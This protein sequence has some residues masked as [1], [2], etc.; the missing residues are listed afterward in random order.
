MKYTPILLTC[1]GLFFGLA[2]PA[3]TK[4]KKADQSTSASKML[5]KTDQARK[6]IASKNKNEA[7]QDITDA[8]DAV[9]VI[10]IQLVPIYP[11]LNQT[12]VLG[13]VITERRRQ[14]GAADRPAVDQTGPATQ[15][16]YT[17][18][19]VDTAKAKEQLNTAKT[20]LQRGDAQGADQALAAVQNGVVLVAVESE[21]SL[22]K[23]RQDL[24]AA[25]AMAQQ[26]RLGDATASLRAAMVNLDAYAKTSGARHAGE[27]AKLQQDIN[28]NIGSLGADSSAA[29]DKI[30]TWWVEIIELSPPDQPR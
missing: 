19:A 14:S 9:N 22:L 21:A 4:S 18:V 6:A 1:A 29:A 7:L 25:K 10:E 12:S 8:L 28:S 27:A 2:A 15:N 24:A 20:A 13:P 3:Q 16:P 26:N 11:E 17:T 5:S 30:D 23:A